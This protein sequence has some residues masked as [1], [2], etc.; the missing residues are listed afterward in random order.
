MPDT[1]KNTNTIPDSSQDP[2]KTL[3]EFLKDSELTPEDKQLLFDQ[4]KTRFKQ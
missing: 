3:A 1:P 2:V 4:A